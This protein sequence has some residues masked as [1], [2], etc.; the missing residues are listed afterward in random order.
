MPKKRKHCRYGPQIDK[1]KVQLYLGQT[2]LSEE[3]WPQDHSGKFIRMQIILYITIL[4]SYP[5]S[6][7]TDRINVIFFCIYIFSPNI[8]MIK[9]SLIIVND[10]RYKITRTYKPSARS[11]QFVHD[12][13]CLLLPMEK[14]LMLCL[15]SY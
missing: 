7:I 12:I 15:P 11:S 5:W 13:F 9:G 2:D 8:I 1:N 14:N 3:A 6:V 4:R 10:L